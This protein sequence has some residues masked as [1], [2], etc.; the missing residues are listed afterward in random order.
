V[1]L[2]GASGSGKSTLVTGVLERLAD[3]AYQFCLVDPEGDYEKFDPAVVVGGAGQAPLLEEVLDVLDAPGQ[4]A[5]TNLTGIPSDQRPSFFHGLAPHLL[6]LRARTGRPHWIVMDE[7]HH[8]LPAAHQPALQM[9]PSHLHSALLITLEPRRLSKPA[10]A[11]VD[12][13]LCVG[14]DAS[15]TIGAFMHEI[16]AVLPVLPPMPL[17]RGEAVLWRRQGDQVPIRFRVRP[18]DSEHRRHRKKYAEGA[19]LP[20]ANFHFRG[21]GERLNLRAQNLT[22]FRQIAEGVDEDTWLHHLRQ[23]DYSRWFRYSIKDEALA[24]EAAAVERDEGMSAGQSRERIIE[25]ISSR[26]TV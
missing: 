3:R 13:L 23:G 15:D 24:D 10:L 17:A 20:E 22:V 11:L 25:L 5:V 26:Y 21:P 14:D 16:G 1:L 18:P 4:N 7:A 9:L 6:E 19:L 2:I 12:T 8:L